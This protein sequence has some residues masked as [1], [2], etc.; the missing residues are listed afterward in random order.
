MESKSSPMRR[1]FMLLTL[2]GVL[3]VI[4][5]GLWQYGPAQS[6]I[7]LALDKAEPARAW[8]MLGLDK[9]RSMFGASKTKATGDGP[10]NSMT[11]AHARGTDAARAASES[12]GETK[13]GQAGKPAGEGGAEAAGEAHEEGQ[14]VKLN[15]DQLQEFGIEVGVAAEGPI[16][17]QI[18]RPAE[19]KFDGDRLIHVLPRVGGIAT[20]VTVTQ[21]Q[22]VKK[23]ALLATLSSRE[24]AELK[25][26]Y[27]ADVERRGLARETFDRESR[28]WE[29]KISSEKEYLD[30]KS[31]LAEAEIALRASGQ[32]L[33]ALGFSQ[34][35]INALKAS[36][37]DDLTK[38]AIL[39]STDGTVIQRHI[40]LGE[41]VSSNE[42][43]FIIADASTVWVDVTIYPNDMTAVR[44]G[45]TIRIDLGDGNPI[46]GKIAF[47]TPNV[48]EETR[49]ASARAII[50]TDGRLKPGMFVSATIDVG[51]EQARVRLPKSAVQNYANGS[52]VFVKD[53]DAFEPR[54]VQVGRDNAQFVEIVSG[55]DTGET[56]V[57]EGA[58][59]VKSLIQKSQMGEG[60]GH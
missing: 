38:Y 59:T 47:V 14:T 10:S 19:I 23:D 30:A 54:P 44:A 39:S 51:E 31:A 48:S 24:L 1:M 45:Q 29:K 41:A 52:V 26:A 17:K 56:Y 8:A 53:G 4:A 5:L 9:A 50:K 60:H 55:L 15:N 18:E 25:A 22:E 6:W 46:V 12:D 42:E 27:L 35:Y 3:V 36:D 11:E 57:A 2:L 32:K 13:G 7:T 40:N 58:F 16:A 33:R 20:E 43:V 34:E 28:L 37:A 49:T 21:G